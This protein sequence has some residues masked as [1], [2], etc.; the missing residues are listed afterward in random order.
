MKS[1]IT[2][3]GFSSGI[4]KVAN[5]TGDCLFHG[6]TEQFP[7]GFGYLA[8]CRMQWQGWG[9]CPMVA[10]SLC[11]TL[12]AIAP[13]LVCGSLLSGTPRPK[14]SSFSRV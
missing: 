12:G 10:L 7:S 8:Y 5:T 4:E 6:V 9:T 11:A 1:V 13:V 2:A 14:T 3:S